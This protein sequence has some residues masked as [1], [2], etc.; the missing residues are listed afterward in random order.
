ME[1]PNR[2]FG[3]SFRPCTYGFTPSILLQKVASSLELGTSLVW[4]PVCFCQLV[5]L[6][7]SV[8]SRAL[9]AALV[10][11]NP[12]PSGVFLPKISQLLP[13]SRKEFLEVYFRL[14][15]SREKIFGQSF[16]M[17]RGECDRLRIVLSALRPI[18]RQILFLKRN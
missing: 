9:P 16:K 15:D 8:I 12:I 5:P 6:H 10:I 2:D 18:K 3:S 14:N 7:L 4:S 17:S 1:T 11:C 13:R